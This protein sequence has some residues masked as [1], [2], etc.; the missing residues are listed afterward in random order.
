QL[1]GEIGGH[2]HD[3]QTRV[4]PAQLGRR[5]LQEVG[6]DVDRNVGTMVVGAD[7]I[8]NDARLRRAPGPELDQRAGAQRLDPARHVLLEQRLLRPS[9]VVL[10]EPRDLLE[11]LRAALVV[12]ELARQLLLRTRQ[13]LPDLREQL[14]LLPSAHQVAEPLL[15]PRAQV[16]SLHSTSRASR[17]PVNCQ[18]ASGGKKLR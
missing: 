4:F 15:W 16:T 10:R 6:A 1:P 8:Q 18:V 3:L 7:R 12:E 5:P 13:A 14:L 17:T 11:E 2:R 9:E